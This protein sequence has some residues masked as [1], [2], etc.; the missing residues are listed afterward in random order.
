MR[1]SSMTCSAARS[2]ARNGRAQ[3][4]DLARY[5]DSDGYQR[6]SFRELWLY[7]DWVVNA[8]NA[9]MPF[10]QFTIEQTGRRPAAASRRRSS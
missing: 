5:A 1:R 4:L 7:R 9:D 6:D 3:W 2:S 8:L 10:D